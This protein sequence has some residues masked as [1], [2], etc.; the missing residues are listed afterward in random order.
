[1]LETIRGILG[2]RKRKQRATPEPPR[3]TGIE[4]HASTELAKRDLA[5][6][7]SFGPEM[8][9]QFL[10]SNMAAGPCAEAANMDGGIFDPSTA[11]LPPFP[12]CPH[13]DQCSCMYR[14]RFEMED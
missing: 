11:P 13:P 4:D 9:A 3:S 1:M 7:L 5:K 14:A 2:L 8:R 10:A 6:L 12:S